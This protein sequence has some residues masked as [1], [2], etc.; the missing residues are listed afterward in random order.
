MIKI[1]IKNIALIIIILSWIYDFL[2]IYKYKTNG[3][4]N[5]GEPIIWFHEKNIQ[6]ISTQ[7]LVST[8]ILVRCLTIEK[9]TMPI[10]NIV[11]FLFFIVGFLIE[12]IV[13]NFYGFR[14]YFNGFGCHI[15]CFF[16]SDF[17]KI[18]SFSI[19]IIYFLMNKKTS[20]TLY[21]YLE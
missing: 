1:F 17:F 4:Y 10:I 16:I 7:L 14:I 8:I 3:G 21:M 9:V 5:I 11:L 15:D 6:Y 12:L 13:Q 2:L 20:L 18:L 19:L